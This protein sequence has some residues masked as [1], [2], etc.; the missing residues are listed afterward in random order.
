MF[1]A[2][3]GEASL[4]EDRAAFADHWSKDAEYYLPDGINTPGIILIRVA[5]SNIRYW[6]GNEQ[7]EIT[8]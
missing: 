1:I 7:G 6:G 2:V 4:I 3:E 5:A 8:V